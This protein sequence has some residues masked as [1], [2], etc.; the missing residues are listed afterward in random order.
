M[1]APELN[2]AWG[3]IVGTAMVVVLS[4]GVVLA[5]VL[6]QRR[7]IAAQRKMYAELE[8]SEKKYKELF[9]NALEGIFQ[10][11]ADGRIIS[12]NPAMAQI[13]GYSSEVEM[14][15]SN[16]DF[17]KELCLHPERFEELKNIL[18]HQ[19]E[20]HGFQL[21]G[22]KKDGTR[23]WLS[24]NV[25]A[26]YDKA[27][28]LLHYEGSLEDITTRREAEEVIQ[29]LPRRV[30]EAEE[31]ERKRV[32]RDLHDGVGQTLSVARMRIGAM[33]DALRRSD[34]AVPENLEKAADLVGQ[35]LHEVRRIS[36]NLRPIELD[37]LGFVAA[38][39]RLCDQFGERTAINVSVKTA[40]NLPPLSDETVLAAYR[41]VQEG[42]NNIEKH[43]KADMVSVSVSGTDD[44]LNI[45]LEDNGTGFE[46]SA[47]K[48][49]SDESGR[50]LIGIR[51]RIS[52]LGGTLDIS[53]APTSGTTIYVHLPLS[54]ASKFQG[55]SR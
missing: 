4:G 48:I 36:R 8:K 15:D 12:I 45:V 28:T 55:G 17:G 23:I 24:G 33:I 39:T 44:T 2:I 43:S 38:V 22:L 14:Q 31:S 29:L 18:N 1:Q 46:L 51:E 54:P 21:E 35:S 34:S 19:R 53:S 5:V 16:I 9:Q 6:S 52:L 41:I 47:S 13:F 49:P 50:G 30:L 42:L 40:A 11:S 10:V 3:I 7:L 25:R 37:S 27:R 20:V 32:A 26:V